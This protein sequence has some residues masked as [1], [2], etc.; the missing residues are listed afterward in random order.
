MK[1]QSIHID[2]YK[3]FEDFDIDFRNEKGEI[4][5]L[6]VLAGVNGCGKTT[7]LKD[8]IADGALLTKNN[9]E[10][11]YIIYKSTRDHSPVQHP[12]V[13]FHN[14][15]ED[16]CVLYLKA[17]NQN[18][19]NIE[20]TIRN[21]V[22]VFIYEKGKTSFDA[23]KEIN[24][25]IKN[26]FEDFDFKISFDG[27]TKDKELKFSNQN[28]DTFYLEGLSGGEFEIISRL[29]SLYI[30][31]IKDRVILIDEP[32]ESIHPSW[33]YRIAPLYQKF[34]EKND[35]Q[36][37]LATH[38]PQ[39]ISSVKAEQIRLLKNYDGKIQVVSDFDRSLGW[40]VDRILLEIQGVGNRPPEIE[41]EFDELSEMI[42]KNKYDTDDFHNKFNKLETLLGYA[43]NDLVLMRLEIAR[44][45]KNNSK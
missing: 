24:R 38:S 20:D 29:F 4:Q 32:E 43:D 13:H 34:A 21:Y 33:Q 5:N 22:D 3:V 45:R 26:I 18:G 15:L 14:Y 28:G 7:L 9:E 2:K 1:I 11:G 31:D 37:I 40:T 6:I 25:S 8:V 10:L 17:G 42:H 36:I 41:K 39:I 27:L 35:C 23:Y 44:K 19:F 16:K 30:A 12:V